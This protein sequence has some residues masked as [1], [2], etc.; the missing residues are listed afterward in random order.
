[1]AFAFPHWFHAHLPERFQHFLLS[2]TSAC[3]PDMSCIRSHKVVPAVCLNHRERNR[4]SA[5]HL[6]SAGS[7]RCYNRY[8]MNHETFFCNT[9]QIGLRQ[10]CHI[11]QRCSFWNIEN[12]G[13]P[14][15]DGFSF[16]D[17]PADQNV[18]AHVLTRSLK[19]KCTILFWQSI[20]TQ[21]AKEPSPLTK[22]L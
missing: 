2:R 3:R 14:P 17:L 21:P 12:C 7:A 18:A 20:K 15:S 10:T 6:S 9:T 1:M 16:L 5:N 13:L 8:F 22:T 19:Y 4:S 11:M